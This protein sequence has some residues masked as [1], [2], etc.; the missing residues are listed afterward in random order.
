MDKGGNSKRK[1]IMDRRDY[2]VGIALKAMLEQFK[3][4]FGLKSTTV[5]SNLR[6]SMHIAKFPNRC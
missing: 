4:L 6:K 3:D 5:L 1:T 2:F